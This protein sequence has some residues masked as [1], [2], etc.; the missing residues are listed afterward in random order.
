[1]QLAGDR[2]SEIKVQKAKSKN[3]AEQ[4][5]GQEWKLEKRK[6]KLEIRKSNVVPLYCQLS[7]ALLVCS[8]VS[9]WN[10]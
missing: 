7:T 5:A 4:R 10:D 8:G 2:Q 3:K 9:D 6:W 1:M